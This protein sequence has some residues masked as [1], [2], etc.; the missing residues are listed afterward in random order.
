MTEMQTPDKPRLHLGCGDRVHSE[1]VNADINA[2]ADGVMDLDVRGGLP[3]PDESF[4]AVYHAHL[5]EHLTPE[6]GKA[7]MDECAR[8]L[9]PGGVLRVTAPDLEGIVTGYLRELDA[10]D[11]GKKGAEE[12]YDWLLVELLDQLVRTRSGGRML[13]WWAGEDV[14]AHDFVEQ[15]MGEQFRRSRT[16]I[17]EHRKAHGSAPEWAT[18][19]PDEPDA[20]AEVEFRRSGEVHRWMYDRFGLRRLL[21]GIGFSKVQR[22]L[23]SESAIE[24]WEGF[25]L[26]I[27]DD[28]RT[29]KPDSIAVEGVKP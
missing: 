27:D 16:V 4:E 23:P 25:L 5:I 24:G 21:R 2:T 6:E 19:E 10:A 14:R 3:F 7:F 26:E 28:G 1:W 29:R 18:T 17:D 15:R 12:R 8:V 22:C 11:R 20:S 9:K 13:R